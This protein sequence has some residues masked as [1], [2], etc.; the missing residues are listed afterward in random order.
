MAG[1]LRIERDG[2]IAS[3]VLDNPARRNAISAAMWRAIPAAVAAL[4]SD[5]D[6]RVLVVRGAGEVAFAAGA[7]VSEFES[8]RMG[9]DPEQVYER[10]AAAALEALEQ[11]PKPVIAQIHGHCLGG[12]LALAL[13]CDLRYC[14]S[15]ARFAI[16]AAR[17][18]VG[19]SLAGHRKLLATVGLA[20]A[21]EIMFSARRYDAEEARQCG[22]VN[23]VLPAAEL[24]SWVRDFAR[25]LA[26]NAPLSLA[27]SKAALQALVAARPDYASTERLIARCFASDDYREGR[28]AFLEKREPHF[29]GA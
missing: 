27:A 16:P 21:T 29:R 4:D 1:E 22:L 14:A 2:P 15:D 20:L 8:T 23:R 10:T 25:L 3:L 24:D 18:G 5:P 26:G 7:D 6:V 12:G 9:E 11:V 19:Y 13:A 28:A 17:L